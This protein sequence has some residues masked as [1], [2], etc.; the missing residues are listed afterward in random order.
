ML[1]ENQTPA[2]TLVQEYMNY[3][4]ERIKARLDTDFK[5]YIGLQVTENPEIMQPK[6]PLDL[7][8][9]LYRLMLNMREPLTEPLKNT[10]ALSALRDTIQD[11]IFTDKSQISSLSY[12]MVQMPYRMEPVEMPKSKFKYDASKAPLSLKPDNFESRQI[13]ISHFD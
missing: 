11:K 4:Y 12:S 6:S 2:G 13:T 5:R 9:V 10:M 8:C 1:R 3:K 7:N